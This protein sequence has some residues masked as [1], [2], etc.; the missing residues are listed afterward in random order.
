MSPAFSAEQGLTCVTPTLTTVA[1]VQDLL[2]SITTFVHMSIPKMEDGNNFGV[3]IQLAAI[4]HI[5]DWA[6]KLDKAVDELS[7]YAATRADALEKCKLP[8]SSTSE[9]QTE[10]KTGS[11]TTTETKK[12]AKSSTSDSPELAWRQQA[13]IAV[14]AL[15]YR[16]SK[17]L[18]E[19]ALLAAATTLDFCDKNQEKLQKPKGS[20]G[21]TGYSSMY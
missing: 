8:S 1:S 4:K 11:E 19:S 7:K 14:D 13:V 20:Q 9:S 12:E 21:G 10:T 16:K 6:D 15:Y 2:Q 18:F 5:S 17:A 3:T